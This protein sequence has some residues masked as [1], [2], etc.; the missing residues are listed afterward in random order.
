MEN[1]RG[2]AKCV[3]VRAEIAE[4]LSIIFGPAAYV[5]AGK[6][7]DEMF[8]VVWRAD[9]NFTESPS[10]LQSPGR[11][12]SSSD[13]WAL[14]SAGRRAE[15]EILGPYT[16]IM[17]YAFSVSPLNMDLSRLNLTLFGLNLTWNGFPMSVVE[18]SYL[19]KWF[20]KERYFDSKVFWCAFYCL[21][22]YPAFFSRILVAGCV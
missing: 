20:Y 5:K 8:C 17:V 14:G 4:T 11:S 19:Q 16:A 9:R 3:P 6:W 22:N 13:G 12:T 10:S 1:R 2:S 18:W 15:C 7:T 21:Y